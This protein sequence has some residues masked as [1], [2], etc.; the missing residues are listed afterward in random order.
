MCQFSLPKINI[1][2][3]DSSQ[4]SPIS[5]SHTFYISK[6][7]KINQIHLKS[8]TITQKHSNSALNQTHNPPFKKRMCV[9]R[10]SI[11]IIEQFLNNKETFSVNLNDCEYQRNVYHQQQCLWQPRRN[12]KRKTVKEKKLR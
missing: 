12:K 2:I 11:K 4:N 9:T 8:T 1:Q 3:L 10:K 5:L 6:S 7:I